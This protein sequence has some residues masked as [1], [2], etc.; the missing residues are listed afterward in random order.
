MMLATTSPT[1]VGSPSVVDIKLSQHPNQFFFPGSTVSGHVVYE[2]GDEEENFELFITFSGI[3]STTFKRSKK[4]TDQATLFQYQHRLHTG[5]R[6]HGGGLIGM[7]RYPFNF[8]FP[9]NTDNRSFVQPRTSIVSHTWAS[10][11]HE[12]PPSFDLETRSSNFVCS[13]EYILSVELYHDKKLSASTQLPIVFLPFRANSFAFR[14]ST[15]SIPGIMQLADNAMSVTRRDSVIEV[16]EEVGFKLTAEAPQ[17][18]IVGRT[19][20]LEATLEFDDSALLEEGFFDPALRIEV[21]R[22]ICT[23]SCRVFRHTTGSTDWGNEE[24]A[25]ALMANPVHT[26]A[27]S[28]SNELRFSFE[29]TMPSACSPTF[30]SFLISNTYHLQALFIADVD[31]KPVEL[32]LH[33]PDIPV[34]SPVA[35]SSGARRFTAPM[36]P[37][38]RRQSHA[39][40]RTLTCQI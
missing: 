40:S 10:S 30:R 19:F 32:T 13:V 9:S 33:A 3:N 38:N 12:L 16:R 6:R 27:T 5:P 14:P 39:F 18:I 37:N 2:S 29:A 15:T 28:R 22:I 17:E 31:T 25:I 4:Y 1:V 35:P 34:L 26:N 20:R 7:S 11:V 8:R 24:T 21:L 36:I 23:T